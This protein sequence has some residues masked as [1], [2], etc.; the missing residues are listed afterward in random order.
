[1]DW[2]CNNIHWKGST[3]FF[4]STGLLPNSPSPKVD[5]RVNCNATSDHQ[6]NPVLLLCPLWNT[7]PSYD[8]ASDLHLTHDSLW[9]QKPTHLKLMNK[10]R[11]AL[12]YIH[13][14]D[15]ARSSCGLRSVC[16]AIRIQRENQ[17]PLT[18][19]QRPSVSS[20]HKKVKLPPQR[21]RTLFPHKLRRW[22]WRRRG[23]CVCGCECVLVSELRLHCPGGPPANLISSAPPSSANRREQI[24]CLILILS[25]R[26]EELYTAHSRSKP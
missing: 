19:K 16:H 3:G 10:I 4:F 17:S 18:T 11:P 6:T 8:P 20:N 7:D 24:H 2:K 26:T 23:L 25:S 5:V 1:M 14:L 9:H 21:K 15:L 22:W 12:R 13:N